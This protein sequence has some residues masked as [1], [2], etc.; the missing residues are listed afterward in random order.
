MKSRAVVSRQSEPSE[1]LYLSL[2]DSVFV[3]VDDIED[4]E[5][6]MVVGY[7]NLHVFLGEMGIFD[8]EHP[9]ASLVTRAPASL[10]AS[11]IKT[12][13]AFGSSSRMCSCACKLDQATPKKYD[14][15]ARRTHIYRR[16]RARSPF[17][18]SS[19]YIARCMTTLTGS[20]F[21]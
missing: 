3:I 9:I 5:Q 20:E 14:P 6:E 4:P 10:V 2:N 19:H 1:D 18:H 8:G 13:I 21:G 17:A 7:I 16:L 11:V 12:S 15:Q